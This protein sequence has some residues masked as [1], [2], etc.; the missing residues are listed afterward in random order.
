MRDGYVLR[1]RWRRCGDTASLTSGR[2]E[3]GAGGSTA[4]SDADADSGT[5]PGTNS[6]TH[7]NAGTNAR[8]NQKP[9]ARHRVRP[10][11]CGGLLSS[12]SWCQLVVRLE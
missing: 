11:G 3:S 1:R 8:A 6:S 4:E 7:A 10:Q 2:I 9:E 5:D 12:V